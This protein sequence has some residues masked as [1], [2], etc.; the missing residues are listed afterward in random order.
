MP[1]LL[2]KIEANIISLFGDSDDTSGTIEYVRSIIGEVGMEDYIL[3]STYEA[4]T[5]DF[6]QVI[7]GE[8]CE[9]PTLF[10]LNKCPTYDELNISY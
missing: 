2:K 1:R 4:I 3:L 7:N 5:Q 10:G 6:S 8:F 9:T